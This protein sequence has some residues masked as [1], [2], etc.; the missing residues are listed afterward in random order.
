M[1][2]ILLLFPEYINPTMTTSTLIMLV[3]PSM[4]MSSPYQIRI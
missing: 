3:Q 4:K 2:L 1:G